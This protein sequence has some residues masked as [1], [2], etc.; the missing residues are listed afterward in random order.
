[1]LHLLSY[2]N[3]FSHSLLSQSHVSFEGK[4][5]LLIVDIPIGIPIPLVFEP[6]MQIPSWNTKLKDYVESMFIFAD[7]FLLK[8]G[9]VILF[10]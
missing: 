5:N 2:S 10:F 8:W 7:C 6:S 3:Q 1:M 4:V 9:G